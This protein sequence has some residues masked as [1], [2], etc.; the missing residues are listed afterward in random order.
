M[1]SKQ[2]PIGFNRYQQLSGPDWPTYKQYR[3]NSTHLKEILDFEYSFKKEIENTKLLDDE[4]YAQ[5]YQTWFVIA[6]TGGKTNGNWLELGAAHPMYGN[7]T[8][9]L[10]KQLNWSGI[11][12]DIQEPSPYEADLWKKRTNTNFINCDAVDYKMPNIP[13]RYDYLSMDIDS[14]KQLD[15]LEN[16]TKN[17]RFS[18]ISYETSWYLLSEES[19]LQTRKSRE[20]L[21]KQGYV[22]LVNGVT[23]F[24]GL[25]ST[26]DN[27]PII[28]EDWWVDP[29]VIDKETIDAYRWITED[30]LEIKKYGVEILFENDPHN[31]VL[32]EG[33]EKL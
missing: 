17:H 24:P 8:Y 3:N 4:C 20:I 29:E 18:T 9:K 7:N 12:I 21:S 33:L 5:A 10:E 26:V 32:D 2:L 15:I 11:S 25:G 19:A 22:L 16:I 31:L 27:R 30:S 13:G 6:L 28:F 1:K 23:V 14:I